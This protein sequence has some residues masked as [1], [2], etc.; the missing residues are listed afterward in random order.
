MVGYLTRSLF[1]AFK[2]LVAARSSRRCT[3]ARRSDSSCAA[4][5]VPNCCFSILHTLNATRNTLKAPPNTLKVP[6]AFA[7]KTVPFPSVRPHSSHCTDLGRQIVQFLIDFTR[8]EKPPGRFTPEAPE[9]RSSNLA[10]ASRWDACKLTKPPC[11]S[12]G[13]LSHLRAALLR[14]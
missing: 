14:H 13:Y 7:S 9:L 5:S 4:D 3:A 6:R 8:C 11:T 1:S 10:I 12:L 2:A